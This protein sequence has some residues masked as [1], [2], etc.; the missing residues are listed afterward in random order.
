MTPERQA[1]LRAEIGA[2]LAARAAGRY[3]THPANQER[4]A[5]ALAA[6]M[7]LAIDEIADA[8]AGAAGQLEFAMEQVEARVRQ[9]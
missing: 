8:V 7:E 9:L 6:I 3:D 2:F 4:Q 1:R 5:D